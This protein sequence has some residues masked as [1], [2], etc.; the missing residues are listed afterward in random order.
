VA[1]NRVHWV[2]SELVLAAL[3][4]RLTQLYNYIYRGVLRN[5]LT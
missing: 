4:F 2:V 5:K 3:N 1:Q